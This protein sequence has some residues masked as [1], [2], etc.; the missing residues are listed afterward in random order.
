MIFFQSIFLG[1]QW[2]MA[3]FLLYTF[4]TE[5]LRSHILEPDL[6]LTFCPA[7]ALV[8]QTLVCSCHSDGDYTLQIVLSFS[9]NFLLDCE[10]S[11]HNLLKSL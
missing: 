4:I 7:K 8:L 3:I 6:T 2:E 5:N 1:F 10:A 9:L 11:F